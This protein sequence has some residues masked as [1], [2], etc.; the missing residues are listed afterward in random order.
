MPEVEPDLLGDIGQLD[1]VQR[2]SSAGGGADIR[3]SGWT[4][5]SSDLVT[6]ALEG[7][8]DRLP[9]GR[10][11]AHTLDRGCGLPVRLERHRPFEQRH[12]RRRRLSLP[13]LEPDLHVLDAVDGNDDRA[14]LRG[15]DPRPEL[16][17]P[18]TARGGAGLTFVAAPECVS[19]DAEVGDDV[20][21][22][23]QRRRPVEL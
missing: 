10:G 6:A 9:E 14:S 18:A 11:V 21:R 17:E 4:T 22:E 20:A 8:L 13:W 2:D 23:L 16:G 5:E 19:G 1:A 3:H 15:A 7:E 12:N